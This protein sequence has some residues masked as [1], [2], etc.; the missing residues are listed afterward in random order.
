MK[1]RLNKYLANSGVASRRKSEE[2][3]KSGIVEVNGKIIDDVGAKVE[4]TDIIKV[5]GKL[6][7]IIKD[8]I[9]LLLNKPIGY[10]CTVSDPHAKKTVLDLLNYK[11]RR[12]YPVGRLDKDSCGAII[13]S[14]DGDFTYKLTHPKHEIY[15][16]YF[17]K[18]LGSPTEKSLD[19]LRDGIEI[20]DY[21]THKS[22]IKKLKTVQGYTELYI[23]IGEGKNRQVRKMFD[24][25]GHKVI[26]LQ[27]VSIGDICLGKLA[28][29][30]N[31]ELTEE[32]INYFKNI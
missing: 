7:K 31:R 17:V 24:A 32:E 23:I 12:L 20:E 4:D 9:Y 14:D 10:T 30:E 16:K 29:G 18:V 6:V 28:L 13:I 19:K 11:N 22:F 25:I 8:N 2:I 3:I 27:R 26:F 5:D 1:M 15:K 21:K